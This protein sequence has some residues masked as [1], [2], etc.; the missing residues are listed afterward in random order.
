MSAGQDDALDTFTIYHRPL[1]LPGVEYA[2]RR[3][4][5]VRGTGVVARE[6]LG[7][8]ATLD[9]AREAVPPGLMRIPRAEGDD[10]VIVETWL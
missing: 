8:F 5:V 9:E 10:P 2:V 6:L 7:T 4:T 3:L 1:D